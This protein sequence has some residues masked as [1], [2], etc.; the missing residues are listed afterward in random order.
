MAQV[1]SCQVNVSV[2][3]IIFERMRANE[4]NISKYVH[5]L[6]TQDLVRRKIMSVQD[7]LEMVVGEDYMEIIQ[8]LAASESNSKEAEAVA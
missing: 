7:I 8:A 6:I 3:P 2:E 5:N 1:R 4:K